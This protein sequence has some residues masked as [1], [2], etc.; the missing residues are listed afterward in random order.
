MKMVEI[1][2]AMMAYDDPISHTT[3]LLVMRNAL[4]V[5]SMGHNLIPL[6]LIRE[7]GLVLDEMPKFQFDTPTI[8]NHAIRA[9]EGVR[10]YP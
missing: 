9:T 2:D 5:P 10:A 3:Y 8:D 4:S 7:A 1:D 6:F